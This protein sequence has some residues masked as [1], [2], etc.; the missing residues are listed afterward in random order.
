MSQTDEGNR[1]TRWRCT[2]VALG[3]EAPSLVLRGGRVFSVF[4][5][6][7]MEGDVALCGPFI[8]GIGSF[9]EGPSVDVSG[10][11]LLPG[12]IDAHFHIESSLLA[13]ASYAEAVIIHGTTTVMEEP[14]ELVNVV[15]PRGVDFFLAAREGLPLDLRIMLPSSV[16]ASPFEEAAGRMT[17]A[18]V[19]RYLSREGVTGLG[20]V[21][22]YDGVL[23]GG[24]IWDVIEAAESRVA[25]GH[26]P[27]LTGSEL[28]AYLAAGPRTDHETSARPLLAERMRLGM[29]LLAREGSASRDLEQILPFL[30]RYGTSRTCLCTDDRHAATLVE[31]HHID[32]MV[33][34]LAAHGLE[35]RE[36]ISAGTSNP[37]GLYRLDDRGFIAPGMRADLIA[38]EDPAA[39]HP[40]LVL[41]RGEIVAKGGRPTRPLPPTPPL[42][43]PPVRLEIKSAEQLVPRVSPGT[44]TVRAV[45]ITPRR[46]ET[47]E[48]HV[49][50]RAPNGRIIPD[51]DADLAYAAVLERHRGTGMVGTGLVVGTGLRK[52]ALA[53][54]VAHDAHHL[55][56]LGRDGETMLAL[57]Q[58]IARAGGGIGVASESGFQVLPLPLAGLMTD[59]PAREVA[60]ILRQLEA[61][62]ARLGVHLEAP[63]MA[64]SFLALSVIPVLRI[65]PRGLL[66]VPSRKI[67][68]VGL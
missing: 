34:T 28:N 20:E 36:A 57:A 49:S 13:P 61:E 46:L 44:R 43:S 19:A 64:L 56:V 41:S 29:W 63:F 31:E 59:R 21:M 48:E 5:G 55:I 4:T 12:F 67:V 1:S 15:G 51:S 2:R 16:P 66:H 32:G 39:P 25:D 3:H 8:A 17:G 11:I 50:V 35:L 24:P 9:P 54:T 30:R 65:T 58:E 60:Q 22:D 14:H 18:D 62:A 52:G 6:E 23:D 53:S 47:Q 10:R 37:A 38:V 33:E 68:P 26:A 27:G 42:E 45:R 40:D 7:L